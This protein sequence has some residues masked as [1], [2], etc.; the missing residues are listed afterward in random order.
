MEP[1]PLPARR[2]SRG[3]RA[4]HGPPA[5]RMPGMRRRGAPQRPRRAARRHAAARQVSCS[6]LHAVTGPQASGP[7]I[8]C[9]VRWE[10]SGQHPRA[11]GRAGDSQA[12]AGHSGEHRPGGPRDPA[13]SS[14]SGSACTS[15]TAARPPRAPAAA[16]RTTIASQRGRSC[17]RSRRR[18][19]A[20][21]R[22]PVVGAAAAARRA[23]GVRLRV[24]RVRHGRIPGRHRCA[25]HPRRGPAQ[26][27]ALA[28]QTKA[29]GGDAS[30]GCVSRG[31]SRWGH[32]RWAARS[33]RS[34]SWRRL[35]AS[36]ARSET[37]NPD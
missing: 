3:A 19:T 5:A 18:R 22:A 35:S 32:A 4:G 2:G 34:C 27:P 24:A 9:A 15:P 28:G 17:T 36:H 7:G 21:V 29:D 25:A 20:L 12:S 1:V 16:G 37:S 10:D 31:R 30:A 11:P 23:A 14:R 6:T 26:H 33:R 13:A 8:G